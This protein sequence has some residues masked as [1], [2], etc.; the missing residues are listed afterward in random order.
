MRKQQAVTTIGRFLL[1]VNPLRDFSVRKKIICSQN[2]PL[3][4]EHTMKGRHRTGHT[5]KRGRLREAR[6]FGNA[7]S[8][9]QT[10]GKS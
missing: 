9:P 6:L 3:G 4:V 1:H 10:G 5:E 7:V 8:G 2:K